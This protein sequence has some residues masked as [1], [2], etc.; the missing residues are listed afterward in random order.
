M[1]K[2]ISK[3][4][5]N[6]SHGVNASSIK[7]SPPGNGDREGYSQNVISGG[8]SGINSMTNAPRRI[9]ISPSKS[10][11][12]P[13]NSNAPSPPRDAPVNLRR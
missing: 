10:S 11:G 2:K 5:D 12:K 13:I 1:I 6:K 7:K 8:P 4:H 3:S 9:N